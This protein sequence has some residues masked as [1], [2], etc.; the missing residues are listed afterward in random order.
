MFCNTYE[1]ASSN[2]IAIVKQTNL[3]QNWREYVHYWKWHVEI[4]FCTKTYNTEW[5]GHCNVSSKHV[6]HKQKTQQ[7]FNLHQNI[8]PPKLTDTLMHITFEN[9]AREMLAT[10]MRNTLI[11]SSSEN[12]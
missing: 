7:G 2:R 11:L 9:I 5:I 8:N 4:F 6:L 12:N 10:H 3:D 1:K